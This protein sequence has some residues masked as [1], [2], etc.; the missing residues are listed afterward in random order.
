M[1]KWHGDCH[2]LVT[3]TMWRT[4]H[5]MKCY[6]QS[7]YVEICEDRVMYHHQIW[8]V[9][10]FDCFKLFWPGSWGLRIAASSQGQC[11][12]ASASSVRPSFTWPALNEQ[13]QRCV[14]RLQLSACWMRRNLMSHAPPKFAPQMSH[15][16]CPT[17]SHMCF[18]D[19]AVY[20]GLEW[21]YVGSVRACQGQDAKMCQL[22][23]Y[24]K[25]PAMPYRCLQWSFGPFDF[26]P[27]IRHSRRWGCFLQWH[28]IL[29]ESSVVLYLQK[30]IKPRSV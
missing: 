15:E 10:I 12:V 4:L 19:L 6:M 2:S 18:Q 30:A 29:L 17:M 1:P 25:C 14:P 24:T 11:F 16:W 13:W 3:L 20:Q 9:V 27:W 21:E 22:P 26:R 8:S 28:Q 5:E 7:G 23:T